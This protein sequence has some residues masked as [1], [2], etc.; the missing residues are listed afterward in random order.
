VVRTEALALAA[1]LWRR[2]GQVA[3]AVEA[4]QRALRVAG[5]ARRPALHLSLAKLYEHRLA[6]PRR[7]LEHA[8]HTLSAEGA[9]PHRQRLQRL[10]ERL[11]RDAAQEPLLPL[12][13][14][15]DFTPLHSSGPPGPGRKA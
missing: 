15:P 8:Q 4:L 12:L 9:E 7:A 3:I 10:Q 5:A 13:K 11:A 2:G 1:E 6:D 14:V